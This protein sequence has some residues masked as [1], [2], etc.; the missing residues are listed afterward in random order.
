MLTTW[1][2]RSKKWMPVP[3]SPCLCIRKGKWGRCGLCKN[4]V[5]GALAIGSALCEE[6][7]APIAESTGLE[8]KQ[9]KA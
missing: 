7:S 4:V 1:E 5:T 8:K 2:R 9:E 3:Q 6:C